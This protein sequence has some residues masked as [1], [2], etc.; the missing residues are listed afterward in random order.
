M[1]SMTG[2]RGASPS[3]QRE[4]GGR[5]C[6]ATGGGG[7]DGGGVQHG[8]GAQRRR[9]GQPGGGVQAGRP[10]RRRGRRGEGRR[11]FG[12]WRGRECDRGGGRG[13]WRPAGGVRR[14]D[15][16]ATQPRRPVEWVTGRRGPR[17]NRRAA[18]LMRNFTPTVE[19]GS[20]RVDGTAFPDGR[21]GHTGEAARTLWVLSR[22]QCYRLPRRS[23]SR[24]M[25]SNSALKLPLPKPRDPCRS[26]SSKNTVGR[27]PIGLVK[28]CSR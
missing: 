3:G 1:T 16:R 21:H 5:D 23:C 15:G 22:R 7:E 10:L 20:C 4:A 12:R 25:A 24:S 18:E 2:R 11:R 19:R 13:R 8:G 26:I 28:I 6:T 27:S 9:G 17:T 14:R